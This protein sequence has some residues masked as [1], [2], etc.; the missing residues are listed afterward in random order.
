MTLFNNEVDT[1]NDVFSVSDYINN[2]YQPK[3]D[4]NFLVNDLVIS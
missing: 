1:D 2:N 3:L 4:E